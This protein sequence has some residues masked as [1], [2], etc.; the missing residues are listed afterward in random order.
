[1]FEP[2]RKRMMKLL[3]W[4]PFKKVQ[5]VSIFLWKHNLFPELRSRSHPHMLNIKDSLCRALQRDQLLE[6]ITS[7]LMWHFGA[8]S[9]QDRKQHLK[10]YRAK[11][12]S[13]S[14]GKKHTAPKK[15]ACRITET[16]HH[17]A[18]TKL[19]SFQTYT[20]G[21]LSRW[22]WNGWYLGLTNE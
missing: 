15:A 12:D 21:F 10:S 17:Y 16:I 11:S 19:A 3:V 2:F 13:W 7:S 8:S 1:M 6:R 20:T 9:S 14:S 4:A 18:S 22:R 5:K